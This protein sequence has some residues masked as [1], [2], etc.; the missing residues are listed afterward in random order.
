[1]NFKHSVIISREAKI[2][3]QM[4]STRTKL[5]ERDSSYKENKTKYVIKT[6][7][8]KKLTVKSALNKLPRFSI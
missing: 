3:Q 8:P 6:F 5:I 4:K 1:M 2:I 7:P